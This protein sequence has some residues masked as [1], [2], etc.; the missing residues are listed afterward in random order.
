M[1]RLVKYARSKRTFNIWRYLKKKEDKIYVYLYQLHSIL[2]N[3][4]DWDHKCVSIATRNCHICACNEDSA[5]LLAYKCLCIYNTREML[6]VQGR[7]YTY[8]WAN[9]LGGSANG[10]S[11]CWSNSNS[12]IYMLLSISYQN[13]LEC[14][15]ISTC[16]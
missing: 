14:L 8:D 5:A 13:I 2:T 10:Y 9:S 11:R 12:H 3:K 7:A 4:T 15:Y 1:A 16:V 6:F